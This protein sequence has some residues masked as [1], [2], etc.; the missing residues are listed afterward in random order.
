[1]S[2]ATGDTLRKCRGR[3][4]LRRWRERNV[5]RGVCAVATRTNDAGGRLT[6]RPRLLSRTFWGVVHRSSGHSCR[7][8]A[9]SIAF[10]FAMKTSTTQRSFARFPV[11][12]F[13]P[14]PRAAVLAGLVLAALA[15]PAVAGPIN[16]PPGPVTSTYKTLTEV[17]PRIAISGPV[18][19][20]TPGSYY[21]TRNI[22]VGSND[23][24]ITISNNFVTLDLN[25]FT[26]AGGRT[27]VIILVPSTTGDIVIKNGTVRN[28]SGSGIFSTAAQSNLDAPPVT[29]RDVR[30]ESVNDAGIFLG[31]RSVIENVTISGNAASTTSSGITVGASST[32]RNT[33][34]DGV[35][36]RGVLAGP[37]STLDGV[38][39]TNA[40]TEGV[41]VGI[42]SRITSSTIISALSGFALED[43]STITASTVSNTTSGYGFSLGL[44]ASATG[45][46]ANNIVGDG[47]VLGTAST[48]LDSK[49]TTITGNGIVTDLLGGSTID[50]CSVFNV[51]LNG[52]QLSGGNIVTNCTTSLTG[53]FSTFGG[54]NSSGIIATGNGNRIENNRMLSGFYGVFITTGATSNAVYRNTAIGTN[55]GFS[56]N[57]GATNRIG[58]VQSAG[59][60]VGAWDNTV[61]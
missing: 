24:V 2:R 17:E 4:Y 27:G 28:S 7:N 30:V 48:L 54:P 19:I 58:T 36:L 29:V 35:A 34:V 57:G 18:N 45:C 43:Y 33:R 46:N 21:L 20:V 53:S 56:N 1:M 59:P 3:K 22:T 50:R 8:R 26:I 49:A 15:G 39:V 61:Q 13:G 55:V 41:R 32:I 25:G 31:A 44:G 11:P 12:T 5:A 47:Y 10:V 60:A 40:G 14:A 23:D 9:A 51:G 6:G 52:I 42:S 16:P 38:N 37:F